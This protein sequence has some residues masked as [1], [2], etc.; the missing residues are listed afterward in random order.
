M[1]SHILLAKA[2]LL[3][4]QWVIQ[5]FDYNRKIVLEL[6]FQFYCLSFFCTSVSG[7]G[8]VVDAILDRIVNLAHRIALEGKFS[9]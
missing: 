7:E 4:Q 5:L 8:M 1:L 2:I 3:V 6:V 9:S